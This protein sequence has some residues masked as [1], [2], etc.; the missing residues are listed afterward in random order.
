MKTNQ[1][2]TT[3]IPVNDEYASLLGKAVY[4]FAYYEWIII[5]I[6]DNLR[7]GFVAKYSRPKK[8]P[9]T[10]G[11]VKKSLLKII[12]QTTFPISFVTK[13]EMDNFYNQFNNLI[14]KRNALIHAH[15]ITET[16]GSQILAYQTKPSKTI[17]DMIW[18]KQKI[19]ELIQEIDKSAVE[20]GIILDK[21]R[22][23]SSQ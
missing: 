10:S 11:A 23:K 4:V 22:N 19:E 12:N 21:L 2:T 9:M 15:P 17:S 8:S 20:A 5:Y 7:S 6:I 16:N 1:Y 18:S 13:I 3:K 14:E